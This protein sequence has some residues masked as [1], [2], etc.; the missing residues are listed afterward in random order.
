[1]QLRYS[2]SICNDSVDGNV[3]LVLVSL[4]DHK[5]INIRINVILLKS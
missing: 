1:M 5:Y 2:V 4:F 3:Y